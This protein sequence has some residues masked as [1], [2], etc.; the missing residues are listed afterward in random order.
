MVLLLAG[1]ANP[2]YAQGPEPLQPPQPPI[3]T[4]PDRST[5]PDLIGYLSFIV[6]NPFASEPCLSEPTGGEWYDVGFQI[7][8]LIWIV[9]NLFRQLFCFLLTMFQSLF[10]VLANIAN[11]IIAAL[12][13][14]W[15]NFIYGI[16][17][18]AHIWHM[19]WFWLETLRWWLNDIWG[20]LWLIGAWI[21]LLLS[22]AIQAFSLMLQFILTILALIFSLWIGIL[23]Y[24]GGLAF[25]AVLQIML[26]ISGTTTPAVLVNTHIVYLMVRGSL[27]AIRDSWLVWLLRLCYAMIYASFI[28]WFSRFLRAGGE[29]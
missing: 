27:E 17:I 14:I 2:A 26:A 24:I 15:R 3:L 11:L 12:N 8:R 28:W 16:L 21:S 9:Q 10:N 20:L 23:G 19:L 4:L 1:L 22:L 6:P 18:L 13:D 7:Q 29:A 5:L 25:G